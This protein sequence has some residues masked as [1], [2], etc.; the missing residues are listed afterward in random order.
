VAQQPQSLYPEDAPIRVLA[1]S[2]IRSLKRAFPNNKLSMRGLIRSRVMIYPAAVTVNLRRLHRDFTEMAQDASP[3]GASSLLSV[4]NAVC[5]HLSRFHRRPS[6]HLVV[7]HARRAMAL[8][9]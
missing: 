5:R 2:S 6:R 4:K 9:G 3:E 1:E 8:L 7:R